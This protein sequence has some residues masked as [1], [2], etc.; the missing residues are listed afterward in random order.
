[1]GFFQDQIT[2]NCSGYDD[3]NRDDELMMMG[4]A[5]MMVMMMIWKHFANRGLLPVGRR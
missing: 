5:M 2:R 3:D 1:M 4:M